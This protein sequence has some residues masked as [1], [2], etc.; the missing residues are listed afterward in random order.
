M[1]TI[2]FT[3][4]KILLGRLNQGYDMDGSCSMHETEGKSYQF[5]IRKPGG[6]KHQSED[7]HIN[8]NII[9]KRILE[10]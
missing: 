6:K 7:L 4:H 9:L 8:G 10:K 1:M 3:L 5:F 2:I